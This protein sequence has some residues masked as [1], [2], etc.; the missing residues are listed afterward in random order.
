VQLLLHNNQPT[1][2]SDHF[3]ATSWSGTKFTSRGLI[4]FARIED[5]CRKIGRFYLHSRPPVEC[6][7]CGGSDC[8]QSHDSFDDKGQA[9]TS[10]HDEG[11]CF[12]GSAYYPGRDLN[13]K[14]LSSTSDVGSN[15]EQFS[16]A[17]PPETYTN[18][19][20]LNQVT[21]GRYYSGWHC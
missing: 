18:D 8:I 21:S 9:C 17:V 6:W 11:E 12:L 7:E 4:Y 3:C 16:A 19:V 2:T 14:V 10:Q 20:M 5:T 13:A 15:Q 1:I